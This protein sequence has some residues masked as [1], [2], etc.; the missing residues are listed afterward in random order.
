MPKQG[1]PSPEARYTYMTKKG[2][3][4]DA[5]LKFRCKSTVYFLFAQTIM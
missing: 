2:R 5:V 4:R 1:G 3:Q